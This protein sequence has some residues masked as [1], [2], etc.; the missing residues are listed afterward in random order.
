MNL[1]NRKGVMYK[2]VAISVLMELSPFVMMK[3]ERKG[4]QTIMEIVNVTNLKKAYGEFL[5]VSEISFSDAGSYNH[6]RK[7][8]LFI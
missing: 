1:L 8:R 5:A 4:V 7:K 2:G 3:V 6:I